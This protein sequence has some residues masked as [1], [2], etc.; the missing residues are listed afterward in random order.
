MNIRELFKILLP[1]THLNRSLRILIIVNTFMV[2]VIGLFAPFY[3]IFVVGLGGNIAFAGFSWALFSIVCGILILLFTRW[4]L[5]I[6]EQELLLA[7]GYLLRGLVFLSYAFMGSMFQLI[8][9]QVLWGIAAAIGTPA[10]D[11]VY[12]THTTQAESIVQWG[13]WEG[14]AA[15]AT[16]LAALI[17]G[18]LIQSFG[19]ASIFLSMSII[20]FALGI[21]IWRLPREIL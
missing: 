4:E 17:G 5:Q 18:I 15:I 3:A 10:F 19:Y 16:G 7:L 12:Q 9:T 6:K 13:G 1:Q 2:F 14:I 8:I 20:S 11:A 21:Y